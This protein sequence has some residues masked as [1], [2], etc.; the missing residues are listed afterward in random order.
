MIFIL[1]HMIFV[2]SHMI[3]ILGH[4]IFEC[5]PSGGE[6]L[7]LLFSA[8][9][10]EVRALGLSF[11]WKHSTPSLPTLKHKSQHLIRDSNWVRVHGLVLTSNGPH[12]QWHFLMMHKLQAFQV[13]SQY[14]S[15]HTLLRSLVGCELQTQLTVYVHNITCN[16]CASFGWQWGGRRPLH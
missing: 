15:T 11:L 1:G 6:N 10:G 13:L 7:P 2:L 8:T 5:S 16:G 4:M 3:F 12:R 14:L 9:D